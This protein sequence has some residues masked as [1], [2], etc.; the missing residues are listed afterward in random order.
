MNWTVTIP[1][2]PPSGNHMYERQ[3]GGEQVRKKPGVETYQSDATG[4]IRRAM[5]SGWTPGRRVI[6]R[7]RFFVGRAVDATNAMKVI[8][9]AIGEALCPG[10]DP[11]RCCR[12][13]DDRFL[14]QAWELEI[15]F[16]EP[17]VVLEIENA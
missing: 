4:F 11:P 16:K 3:R 8:E 6:I 9:D 1:G 13:F 15:G 2:Q 10:I 14:C 17:R 12:A 7:F 5:P